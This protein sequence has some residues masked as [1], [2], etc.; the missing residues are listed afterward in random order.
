MRRVLVEVKPNY[1]EDETPI[2]ID[3]DGSL[4]IDDH[5]TYGIG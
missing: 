5:L 4:S 3:E 1:D 2:I